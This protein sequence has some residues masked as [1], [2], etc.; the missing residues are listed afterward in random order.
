MNESSDP[1]L[2]LGWLDA[3]RWLSPWPGHWYTRPS[4]LMALVLGIYCP[5][6]LMWELASV[7]RAELAKP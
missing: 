5:V 1:D 7:L 4:L 3:R 2:A 6:K